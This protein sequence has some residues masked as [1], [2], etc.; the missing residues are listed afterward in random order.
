MSHPHST[1]ISILDQCAEALWLLV[2]TALPLVFCPLFATAFELPKVVLFK[3]LTGLLALVTLIKMVL[4]KGIRLPKIRGSKAFGFLLIFLGVEILSAM[5]SRAPWISFLGW[6]PRF[7]GVVTHLYYILFGLLLWLN[8]ERKDQKDRIWKAMIIAVTA[9]SILAV[10]QAFGFFS[11]AGDETFLGRAYSTLGHPD[12]LGAWLAFMSPIL[13]WL[14]LRNRWR[15]FS[16][17][18]FLLAVIAIL[19]SGS[20]AAVLGLLVGVVLVGFWTL[21]QAGLKRYWKKIVLLF[22]SFVLVL[23]ISLAASGRLLPNAETS[24][25][26]QSRLILWKS[27]VQLVAE[28]PVFGYGPETIELNILKYLGPEFNRL[29]RLGSVP[30]HTHNFYLDLAIGSGVLG[31]LAFLGFIITFLIQKIRRLKMDGENAGLIAAL[32]V[33]LLVNFTGFPVTVT[34]VYFVLAII[35]LSFEEREERNW[36]KLG[37]WRYAIGLLVLGTVLA[38]TF[39][40]DVPM[41]R[42]DAAFKKEDVLDAIQLSPRTLYYHWS[43]CNRGEQHSPDS[44]VAAQIGGGDPI[45]VL[46]LATNRTYSHSMLTF[47]VAAKEAPN[48]APLYLEWGKAQLK[49]GQKKEAEYTLQKYLN[50]VPPADERDRIFYKLN[51]D[52]DQVFELLKQAQP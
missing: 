18:A 43:L 24:R 15:V 45:S 44:L 17:S 10:V 37:V 32:I 31:A 49:F 6:Y 2:I 42:A 25:S 19:L 52:F 30:D 35:L 40:L 11:W 1:K 16:L 38:N 33:F 41:L 28:H 47:E 39:Y 3:S 48:Y 7:Q 29:E 14:V 46:C 9:V 51:P 5:L 12:F 4:G 26:V 50:L 36:V 23:G 34:W 22:V 8:L 20:R 13:L 21:G 27:A